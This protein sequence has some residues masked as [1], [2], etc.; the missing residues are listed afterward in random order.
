V[1]IIIKQSSIY[2][3]LVG[4]FQRSLV[5]PSQ[6]RNKKRKKSQETSRKDTYENSM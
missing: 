5:V 3:S 6:T 2:P 4:V 1:D